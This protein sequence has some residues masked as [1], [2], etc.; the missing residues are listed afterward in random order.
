M[1]IDHDM[2]AMVLPKSMKNRVDAEVLRNIEAMCDDE[3]LADT[4]KEN[5][6]S[7]TSVLNEGKFKM[8]DYLTAV[9][10]STYKLLGDT[11]QLAYTK[12]FPEKMLKWKTEG[13]E[14]KE[15]ARY[16]TGFNQSKLVKLIM[17][18]GRMPTHLLNADVFQ[19]AIN[20]QAYLMMNASSEKIQTDAANS[21]LTH[22]KSPEAQK[23]ELGVSLKSN[24]VIEELHQTTMKL[25][26]QQQSMIDAR[27]YNAREIAHQPL[28]IEMEKSDED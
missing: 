24:S 3:G 2:L 10:Y 18:Q 21:L 11:N 7:Y 14:Q 5:I 25:A 9:K 16:T 12:T 19:A 13:K 22:L 6:I 26:A 20:R 8:Q 4:F 1:D 23:I 28:I 17:A 15:I 27:V